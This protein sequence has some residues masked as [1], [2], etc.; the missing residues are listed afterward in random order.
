VL[1]TH[2][3]STI[4]TYAMERVSEG[5][6]MPRVIAIPD[7]VPLKAAIDD[8]EMIAFLAGPHELDGLILFIPL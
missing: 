7:R 1:L 8:L 4:Q 3:I 5:L 6:V 2:D